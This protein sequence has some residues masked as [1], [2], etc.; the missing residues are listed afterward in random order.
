MTS[1]SILRPSGG[2]SRPGEPPQA[3]VE[4]DRDGGPDC[5]REK[6]RPVALALILALTV[7]SRGRL[8]ITNDPS[9]AVRVPSRCETAGGRVAQAALNPCPFCL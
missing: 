5:P 1:P 7:H 8:L 4:G 9:A 2:L 3:A 6:R